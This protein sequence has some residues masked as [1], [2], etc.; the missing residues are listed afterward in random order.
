MKIH[1]K[2]FNRTVSIIYICI[3]VFGLGCVGFSIYMISNLYN[4]N[5]HLQQ[6]KENLE[7]GI[8]K[9]DIFEELHFDDYYSVYVDGDYAVYDDKDSHN[10]IYFTK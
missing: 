4:E 8:N 9:Q 7:N 6:I 10:K 5:L 1:S 3:F 2:L